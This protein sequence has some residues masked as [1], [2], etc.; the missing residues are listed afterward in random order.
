MTQFSNPT[1]QQSAAAPQ[2][3]AA[4]ISRETLL[5]YLI[6]ASQTMRRVELGV[7]IVG[8]LCMIV[9]VLLVA[10]LIDHWLWTFNVP[11]RLAVFGFLVGW[12][13]WW[14]PRR[15]VPLLFKPIHPEHT[16][17]K[18]ELQFPQLKE[19][20]ISW[21]QLSSENA[22]PKGVL[23]VVGRFAVRNLGGHD[24]SSIIDAANLIRLAALLFSFVM[25]GT[26]YFFV[27]PKS[28]TTSLSRM[29]M[30]W[31]NIAPAARV[32]I[33][34][35][36]PGDATITQGS[37]LPLAVTVRGMH[38]GDSVRVRYDLSDGQLVGQKLSMKKEIE[39]INYRLDFGNSF[40]GIHQPLQ[41]WIEA[42]D[43]TAGPFAVKVQVV[44]IVAIDRMEYE[45]PTYTKLKATTIKNDG[46]IEA[47]EGT[48]V[49]LFAHSNQPMSKSRIEFDPIVNK[50]VTQ[51][52]SSLLDLETQDTKLR[53][54][55]LLKL[56]DEKSNPT[57]STYRIKA[58][59]S[60][61]EPNHEPVIYKI[62]VIGDYPPEVRLQSDLPAQI[63]VPVNGAQEIEMRAVDPDYGLT[64]LRATLSQNKK[65]IVDQPLFESKEGV[66]TQIVRSYTIRPSE[67]GLKVGDQLEFRAIATDNRNQVGTEIPEPNE[68][69][70]TPLSIQ[71]VEA[72][73]ASESDKE[74]SA[75]NGSKNKNEPP[76]TSKTQKGNSDSLSKQKDGQQPNSQPKESN[77]DTS[78]PNN[79]QEPGT[80]KPKNE[81]RAAS[82]KQNGN[83]QQEQGGKKKSQPDGTGAGNE[84]G[85]GSTDESSS[86]GQSSKSQ[87]SNANKSQSKSSRGG[88][89]NG[90]E[91]SDSQQDSN[92]DNSAS[93]SGG[94]SARSN[95]NA[96]SQSGDPG[97]S[98]QELADDSS[99]PSEPRHDGKTFEQID[100][101]RRE[102]ENQQTQKAADGSA[103]KDAKS[104]EGTDG[105]NNQG[106][107]QSA[108]QGTKPQNDGKNNDAPSNVKPTKDDGSQNQPGK[109]TADPSQK[110]SNSTKE[111]SGSKTSDDKSSADKS[112]ADK[113][114]GEKSSGDKSSGDKSSGDKS[115][116]D[117]SSGDKSS[118][119][120]SSGD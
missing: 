25:T 99:D 55:W 82:G 86:D 61:G 105:N 10:V 84:S 87:G 76:S 112:P 117:K 68:A 50:G 94:S 43:A 113:S 107:K 81:D 22:A 46:T 74:K 2:A 78:N 21:L 27:S 36:S 119:D 44:P 62:K 110:N 120:K 114:S 49:R 13:V 116:G 95:K 118:G 60:L 8:W 111:P 33:V 101:I 54:S 57:R 104:S 40:G 48:R 109:Q 102:K 17:R 15:I 41:Y 16:A 115:S 79:K 52:A 24:S 83:K 90:Q 26:I 37:H 64:S 63:Q 35:V 51:G 7:G 73:P 77:G 97:S 9:T 6:Q 69:T 32:Q 11:A 56:N 1:I 93:K 98:E 75:N 65:S 31:A 20:L 19:S 103:P 80:D 108:T 18:I 47:P 67:L 59:N 91:G 38:Q 100:Q 39:G 72:R 70:S 4:Q 12:S 45:Y 14:V 28:G 23:A 106:N 58:F 85:E 89:Q 5:N 71:V 53:G 96:S 3:Q 30:P 34:D 29:L 92:T 42:G 88:E 66:T